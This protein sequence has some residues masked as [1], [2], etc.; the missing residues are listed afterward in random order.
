MP[1]A[2]SL[3]D[4]L[5]DHFY[6]KSLDSKSPFF[7]PT[8]LQNQTDP[9]YEPYQDSTWSPSLLG[10]PPQG[11]VTVCATGRDGFP[12]I[13]VANTTQLVFT[14]VLVLGLSNARLG[15]PTIDEDAITSTVQFGQLT[16]LPYPNRPG[17]SNLPATVP[18]TITISGSYN[19]QQ[20]CCPTTD[21]TTCS[22]PDVTLAG[23]GTFVAQITNATATGLV[24]IAPNASTNATQLIATVDTLTFTTN[25]NNFTVS[26]TLE[27]ITDPDDQ[28][29]FQE[30][31]DSTLSNN[32]TLQIFVDRLNSILTSSD[33]KTRFGALITAAINTFLE[34]MGT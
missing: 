19:L 1:S 16:G 25:T 32:A 26:A 14:N 29:S 12:M 10:L 11:A 30:F 22:G 33:T 24:R 20:G 6:L 27:E 4:F 21:N 7:L 17:L 23:Y 8:L 5:V 2:P 18:T 28:Q 13:P 3:F 31:V 9:T 34:S 15:L